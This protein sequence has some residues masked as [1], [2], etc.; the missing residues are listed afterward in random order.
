MSS[1]ENTE[2]KV[3]ETKPAETTEVWSALCSDELAL[4]LRRTENVS[5]RQEPNGGMAVTGVCCRLLRPCPRSQCLWSACGRAC[6]GW[7][8]TFV[9]VAVVKTL[10]LVSWMLMFWWSGYWFR[11]RAR[12]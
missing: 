6:F 3:E 4:R 1:T 8:G 9:A 10:V 12:R 11:L 2:P 5:S 7:R